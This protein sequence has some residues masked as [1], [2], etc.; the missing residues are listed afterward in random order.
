LNFEVENLEAEYKRLK[1]L[2]IGEISEIL[3][4]NVHRPYYYFN[5][6]DPDGNVLEITGKMD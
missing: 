2:S 4:V 5:I 3:Y 6:I 1:A